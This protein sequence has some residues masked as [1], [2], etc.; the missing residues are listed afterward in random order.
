MACCD[1]G[2]GLIPERELRATL[3][4]RNRL[5]VKATA[6]RIRVF[7]CAGGTHREVPHRRSH[8]IIRQSFN[9]AI[10]GAATCTAGERIKITAIGRIQHLREAALARCEICQHERA[11][12]TRY[13]AWR[14]NKAVLAAWGERCQTL[15]IDRCVWRQCHAEMVEEPIKRRGGA[16]DLD[17]STIARVADE[18]AES[19]GARQMVDIGTKPHT[20]H[21]TSDVQ[22]QSP[23]RSRSTSRSTDCSMTDCAAGC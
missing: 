5:G 21:R 23:H 3:R 6:V 10:T 17:R 13:G 16:F 1:R 2:A 20:L 11:A 12:I 4:T 18:A 8:A 14:N 7:R 15:P 9:Y 19:L 22:P